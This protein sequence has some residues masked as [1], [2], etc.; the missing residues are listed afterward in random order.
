MKAMGGYMMELY[1]IKRGEAG[2]YIGDS[3]HPLAEIVIEDL[4]DKIMIFHTEVRPEL[5]GQGIGRRLV[6]EVVALA[7]QE[8][9]MLLVLCDFAEKL[10]LN[11]PAVQSLLI[12]QS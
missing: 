6:Y 5:S 7:R 2:F 9:K 11:D 10:L 4:K 8:Q 3:D 12:R 1:E